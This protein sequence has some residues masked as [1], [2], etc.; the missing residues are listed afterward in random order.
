HSA[1][2]SNCPVRS[3]KWA[4]FAGLTGWVSGAILRTGA[5]SFIGYLPVCSILVIGL[6]AVEEPFEGGEVVTGGGFALIHRRVGVWPQGAGNDVVRHGLER[7]AGPH[8]IELRLTGP[9]QIV[10]LVVGSGDRLAAHQDAVIG[11]EQHRPVR[12]EHARKALPL[13]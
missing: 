1:I 8:R 10:E 12:A 6:V 11:H 3:T 4:N 5:T 7:P 2:L 9:L 13:R